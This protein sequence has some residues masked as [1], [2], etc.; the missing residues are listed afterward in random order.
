MSV[1]E[2]PEVGETDP[3]LSRDLSFGG[4][5]T[6]RRVGGQGGQDAARR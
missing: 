6:A 3:T 2:T 1:L 5:L 4:D